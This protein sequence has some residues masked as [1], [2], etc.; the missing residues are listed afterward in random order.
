LDELF[1]GVNL[2]G[3][4]GS[5]GVASQLSAQLKAGWRVARVIP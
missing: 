5:R 4:V 1:Q 2:A 3:R